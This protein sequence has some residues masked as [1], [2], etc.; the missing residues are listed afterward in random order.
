MYCGWSI[1]AGEQCGKEDNAERASIDATNKMEPA[2]ASVCQT[3]CGCRR[4][5]PA[6]RDSRQP[7]GGRGM[8]GS[9]LGGVLFAADVELTACRSQGSIFPSLTLFQIAMQPQ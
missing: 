1:L 4:T 5:V 9:G 2:L 8:A 6:Q 7:Q 3:V